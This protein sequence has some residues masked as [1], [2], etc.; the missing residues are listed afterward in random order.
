M[1]EQE[2]ISKINGEH[3]G[4]KNNNENLEEEKREIIIKENI[5][6]K[7]IYMNIKNF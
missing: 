4:E 6:L 2:D 5:L 7:K 3:I 1:S